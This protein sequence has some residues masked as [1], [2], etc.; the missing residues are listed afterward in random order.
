VFVEVDGDRV[1]V[2]VR[3]RGV[4]FDPAAVHADRRGVAE[5]IVGRMSRHGG[6]AVVR[7]SPGQGTEVELNMIRT[8]RE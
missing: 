3:D 4:G 5:S 2:F 7:S 8:P 1:T 6:W